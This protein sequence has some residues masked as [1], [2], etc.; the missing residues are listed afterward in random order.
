MVKIF[1]YDEVP[2]IQTTSGRLKGYFY[3]GEYIFK[4]IP[5]AHAERFQ[6]PSEA[7][8]DKPGERSGALV[9]QRRAALSLAKGWG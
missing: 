1:Q 8:W 6:M 5:Y 9:G 3:N 4:G 7:K 2:E